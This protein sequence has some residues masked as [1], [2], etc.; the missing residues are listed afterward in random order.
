MD[1]PSII[2]SHILHRLSL[3]LVIPS[4]VFSPNIEEV[5]NLLRFLGCLWLL[6]ILLCL[7]FL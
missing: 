2:I 4:V 7:V 6:V 1:F 5:S 3:H